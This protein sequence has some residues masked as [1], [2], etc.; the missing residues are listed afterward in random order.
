MDTAPTAST[1]ASATAAAAPTSTDLMIALSHI[2]Q[3]IPL[4]DYRPGGLTHLLPTL[5]TPLLPTTDPASD[6][7]RYRANV[8]HAFRVSTE[9][10]SR[11]LPGSPVGSALDLAERL[12]RVADEKERLLRV[13]KKRRLFVEQEKVLEVNSWG[14]AVPPPKQVVGEGKKEEVGWKSLLPS[15]NPTSFSATEPIPPPSSPQTLGTYL[16]AL[17]EYL[18]TAWGAGVAPTGIGLKQVKVR[19]ASWGQEGFS[20]E[21]QVKPLIRA[22]I[23]ATPTYTP[24][25][26][27]ISVD[28][29]GLV[30]GGFAEEITSTTS[31]KFPVFRT[32][33]A[34]ILSQTH[35]ALSPHPY[36]KEGDV[37]TAHTPLTEV[38]ARLL[39][40]ASAFQS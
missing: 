24:Q 17:Q 3:L 10:S 31:S 36:A 8:D 16:N 32:L 35:R 2:Q 9:L 15:Q 25:G 12:M 4:L 11:V 7:Q 13:R 23:D 21:L 5:L 18:R 38:V 40:S 22:V 27:L 1:S 20:L 26:Q 19:V 28:V 14:P 37:W 6:M 29:A 39:L 33:S 34:E 30:V